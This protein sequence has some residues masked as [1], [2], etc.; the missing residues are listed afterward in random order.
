MGTQY[1][2]K[3]HLLT[4]VNN[5]E[6]DLKIAFI[7]HPDSG[8]TT[9]LQRL[10][11]ENLDTLKIEQKMSGTFKLSFRTRYLDQSNSQYTLL[12]KK[13]ST[14]KSTV[15]IDTPGHKGYTPYL[16]SLIDFRD[17]LFVLIDPG[18]ALQS[19]ISYFKLARLFNPKKIIILQNKVDLYPIEILQKNYTQILNEV[20][21]FNIDEVLVFPISR[22]QGRGLQKILY[23][24][25]ERKPKT[26]T[27][28]KPVFFIFKSFNTN[29]PGTALQ[30]LIGGLR[31]GI[32]YG[33]T[34]HIQDLTF[35][36]LE[37]LKK[38]E[39]IIEELSILQAL[40]DKNA[41]THL[42][43]GNVYT[44][45]LDLDPFYTAGDALSNSILFSAESTYQSYRKLV[46]NSQV[47][48]PANTRC[49]ITINNKKKL[50]YITPSDPNKLT[51]TF[52]VPILL[53]EVEMK[54]PIYLFVKQGLSWKL[55]DKCFV[56]S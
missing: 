49:L 10:L 6:H 47:E 23:T 36:F 1:K 53:H 33:P 7:G 19:Q 38:K 37:N 31:G 28:A 27:T 41:V 30:K 18:V 32:Y 26:K 11:G 40:S 35:L 34:I 24:I 16:R 39:N 22:T 12:L 25:S 21:N 15:F 51:V 14:S 17:I 2:K 8:K 46:I 9:L 42:K 29:K 5:N 44:L 54:D 43:N 20:K 4:S 56:W 48:L 3:F 50:G 13:T 45:E 52:D 55:L